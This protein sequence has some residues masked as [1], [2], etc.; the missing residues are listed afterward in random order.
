VRERPFATAS[1]TL[2]IAVGPPNGPPLILLHGVTRRW[3]DFRVLVPS[4]AFDYHLHALDF[5]GHGRSGRT[6]GSYR[7]VD[8]VPDVLTYLRQ[9]IEAPAVLLGHSLGAMVAAAVAAEAPER[10]RALILEDPTF[11]M[12]G[13]RIGETSFPDLFRAFLPHAGSARPVGEIAAELAEAP[14]HVPGR[15]APARLGELR[16]AVNLRAS[17]AGLKRLD[18]DVLTTPLAGRWL[19]GF[20]VPATLARVSCPT[21]LL[22]GDSDAGGALPDEYAAELIALLR[23]GALVKLPGIG[24]NIHGTQPDGMLRFVLPFLDALD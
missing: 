19:E 16:D 6:P 22:Q 21:L 12:T 7:V 9:A 5:R 24:H 2:N 20:D 17:A 1:A 4:L 13:R 8:Y 3:Q 11:E 14:I 15:S 18:P 10:V 23:D